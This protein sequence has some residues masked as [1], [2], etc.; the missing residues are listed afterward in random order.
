[1]R[2]RGELRGHKKLSWWRAELQERRQNEREE[3]ADA[4][5]VVMRDCVAE[6]F[7]NETREESNARRE[8]IR[9]QM[10]GCL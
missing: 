6:R 3:E 2:L 5:R 7:Q 1:M 9:M 10:E 8:N 4:R